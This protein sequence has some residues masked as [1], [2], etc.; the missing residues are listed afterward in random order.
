M[1]MRAK[2]TFRFT[3]DHDNLL[4]SKTIVSHHMILLLVHCISVLYLAIFK[5]HFNKNQSNFVKS[6]S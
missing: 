4:G 3:I 2:P 5:I 1:R 6:Q